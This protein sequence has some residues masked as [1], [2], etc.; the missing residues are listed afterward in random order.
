MIKSVSLEKSTYAELPLKFEA[1][2][3]PIAEAIGLGAAIDYLTTIGLDE[4]EEVEQEL[5]LYATAKLQKYVEIIGA[6]SK[7]GAILSF[8]TPGVHPLD[9][10]TL[11]DEKNIAMR[12][13]HHCSQTTL[14]RFGL[15]S[16]SRISFGIYNTQEEVDLFVEELTSAVK[17]L[18]GPLLKMKST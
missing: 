16:L 8:H 1:G 10:A 4:I 15:T 17:F 14:A 11:L 5:M 3:P 2:T 7:R 9:L 13:G 6:A 12:T 18:E